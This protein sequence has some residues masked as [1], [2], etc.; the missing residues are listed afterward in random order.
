[1]V[2][3]KKISKASKVKIVKFVKKFSGIEYIIFIQNMLENKI[4]L[5]KTSASFCAL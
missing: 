5:S 2:F 1:M 4:N 3:K